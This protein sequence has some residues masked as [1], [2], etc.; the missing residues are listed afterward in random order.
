MTLPSFKQYATLDLLTI[1]IQDLWI[2]WQ[3]HDIIQQKEAYNFTRCFYY[4]KPN[5][6]GPSKLTIK[7]KVDALK[8]WSSRRVVGVV[9]I[10][11]RID[12]STIL[13]ECCKPYCLSQT[14][15]QQT[16]K[17]DE[18]IAHQNNEVL[19]KRTCMEF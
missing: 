1:C 9:W 17:L 11:R 18:P 14:V 4:D 3:D 5:Y 19:K 16:P 13:R 8:I 15:R 6:P 2:L 12:D 10:E 7:I